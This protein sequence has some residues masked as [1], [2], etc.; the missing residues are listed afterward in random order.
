MFLIAEVIDHKYISRTLAL[1][2]LLEPLNTWA[3]ELLTGVSS[4]EWAD[5]PGVLNPW[6][7]CVMHPRADPRHIKHERRTRLA[8][9]EMSI[10]CLS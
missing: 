7:C 2:P 6:L 5:P 8:R 3:D 4:G 10:S 9:E 1:L